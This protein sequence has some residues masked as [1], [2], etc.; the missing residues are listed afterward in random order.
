[1]E[2]QMMTDDKMADFLYRAGTNQSPLFEVL[3]N[4]G[5]V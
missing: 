5:K 3:N 4:A 2:T 1:M